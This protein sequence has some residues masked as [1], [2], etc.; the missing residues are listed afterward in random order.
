M[1]VLPKTPHPPHSSK[2][3]TRTIAAPCEEIQLGTPWTPS[4]T[5]RYEI[6]NS[7]PPTSS[8][9]SQR[10]MFNSLTKTKSEPFQQDLNRPP[11]FPLTFL[12]G[13]QEDT[14]SKPST[15]GVTRPSTL[16]FKT[17]RVLLRRRVQDLDSLH[18]AVQHAYTK[19]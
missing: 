7:S 11:L 2:G 14:S 19:H 3:S 1:R 12:S 13:P 5:K 6:L 4:I 18:Q 15:Y 9:I 8:P 16:H 10:K 17:C